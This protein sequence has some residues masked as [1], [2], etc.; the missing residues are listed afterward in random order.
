M[1]SYKEFLNAAVLLTLVGMPSA[2]AST[3][4]PASA[5]YSVSAYAVGDWGQTLDMSSCCGGTYNNFDLHAQE[6]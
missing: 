3:S 1:L 4:D 2:A 6:I 5:K